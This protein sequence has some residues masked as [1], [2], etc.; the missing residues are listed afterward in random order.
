MPYSSLT[1]CHL[2]GPTGP[3]GASGNPGP[4]GPEGPSGPTGTRGDTGPT[5]PPGLA[6]NTGATG[7][8][9]PTGA[10][11]TGVTGPTG[12]V[13]LTGP[14]GPTGQRGPTGVT[15]PSGSLGP[16]GPT[17]DLGN[18]GP[19][20]ATGPEGSTGPTGEVGH[21][22]MT[23]STGP[24]GSSGATGPIGQTGATGP[25]GVTGPAGLTGPTGVAGAPGE[26]GPT[27]APGDTGPTGSPGPT[28]T[29]LKCLIITAS[30]ITVPT[31][32]DLPPVCDEGDLAL[33]LND[34]NLFICDAMG[35]W[36][37]VNPQP[38][39]P[40]YYFDE[41]NSLIYCIPEPDP[42]AP[43]LLDCPAGSLLIDP[44]TGIL[45][46][47]MGGG[48]WLAKSDLTGPT[49]STGPTG[50]T[51]N[52]G[53]T[54]PTGA[55][56]PTGSTG[57]TGPTGATGPT[58]STGPTGATGNT[59]PTGSTGSTGAVGPTGSTGNTGPTGAT[60]PTGLTG[61]TGST[62]STGATGQTGSTGPTGPI[63]PP[64]LVGATGQV[65]PTGVSNCISEAGVV[66]NG[67]F[68][69]AQGNWTNI[70][71]PLGM[72]FRMA[73]GLVVPIDNDIGLVDTLLYYHAG[74]GALRVGTVTNSD[75]D[76][77]DDMNVGTNSWGNGTDVVASGN[78]SR[79]NGN[80]TQ[81]LGAHSS[82]DGNQTTA[83]GN[84]AH[85]QGLSTVASGRS[86]HA[87]GERSIADGVA[88]DAGGADTNANATYSLTRGFELTVPSTN[89]EGINLFGQ[90]G[91]ART[92]APDPM[93]MD[94]GDLYSIQLG[95]GNSGAVITNPGDGI[96]VILRTT[97]TGANPEGE[98]ISN[99]WDAG[100]ADFAEYLEWVDN[101][102]KNEDR[103]GYFVEWSAGRKIKLAD[104]Y[105][106]ELIAGI[107]SATAGYVGNSAELH[108]KD[109]NLKDEFGRTQTQIVDG[110]LAVVP[111][112]AC[113]HS[114]PYTSRSNRP[115][116]DVVAFIG[117]VRVRDNGFCEPG[118]WCRCED[119]KAVPCVYQPNQRCWYVMERISDKVILIMYK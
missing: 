54:G 99:N 46:E 36:D 110:R 106:P 20:G 87:Q 100:G 50:A 98:G 105:Q 92:T 58:G 2:P 81:A 35:N 72:L 25:T 42:S 53:P 26:T 97:M 51:G 96:S 109:A 70:Q 104:S 75:P 86:S 41:D 47:S 29:I 44:V 61:P 11:C 3:R 24:S 34:G 23:G 66:P 55:T 76:A 69:C 13:G 84:S 117:Q 94:P 27:G 79:A 38:S 103:I 10:G 113:D 12:S 31:V 65:G 33:V 62:G 22:G 9:G 19:T 107:T 14:T 85:A 67:N 40:W 95:G 8:P 48:V 101:N 116:W 93:N 59:G 64:G 45:Y 63:G 68:A 90:H 77:W 114:K 102:P 21:T 30:G 43:V 80:A 91:I 60:G 115:E 89:G 108:W 56:G 82:A 32:T 74:K 6:T 112:P 57:P 5:G 73:N 28:G 37:V 7:P 52:T 71:A 78:N 119:G 111:N 49:G 39:R 88:S 118:K 83:S 1:I 4:E 15:G 16:T 17:G 18:T